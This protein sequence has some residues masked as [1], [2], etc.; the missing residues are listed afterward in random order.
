MSERTP[1]PQAWTPRPVRTCSHLGLGADPFGS[2]VAEA[3]VATAKKS[4]KEITLASFSPR[5]LAAVIWGLIRLIL[6]ITEISGQHSVG[7]R[8]GP[9]GRGI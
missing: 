9:G 1:G 2:P 8:A 5:A 4:R 6:L 3:Q 7:L